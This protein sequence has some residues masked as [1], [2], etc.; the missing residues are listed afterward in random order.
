[1]RKKFFAFF[2]SFPSL[3]IQKYFEINSLLVVSFVSYCFV[4]FVGFYWYTKS[5]LVEFIIVDWKKDVN[6][7]SSEDNLWSILYLTG[8]LTMVPD[9]K[10]SSAVPSATSALMIPNTEIRE[11]YE[12]TIIQWFRDSAQAWNRESLFQAAWN[13]DVTTLTAEMNQLLQKTIS[14]HD[15]RENFYP[16]FLAGIFADAGYMVESI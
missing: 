4:V 13:G 5:I 1:M 10:L 8:Y 3:K 15:Y 16:A 9:K 6:K 14:Y 12:S 11:I 2:T 7:S